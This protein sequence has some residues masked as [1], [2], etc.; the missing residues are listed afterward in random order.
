MTTVHAATQ[1]TIPQAFEQLVRN[2][3][4]KMIAT[5]ATVSLFLYV[6]EAA[7]AF[8]ILFGS[9]FL[10]ALVWKFFSLAGHS[11]RRK[12]RPV[13]NAKTAAN[14][15]NLIG[16]CIVSLILGGGLIFAAQAVGFGAS[17]LVSIGLVS[18]IAGLA[19]RD[20]ILNGVCAILIFAGGEFYEG[21]YLYLD[22]IH[23]GFVIV[24]GMQKT[25]LKRE[26]DGQKKWIKIPNQLVYQNAY[27]IS[28]GPAS[29][30][31]IKTVKPQKRQIG[32]TIEMGDEIFQVDAATA[33]HNR[34]L[35]Y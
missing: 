22:A 35:H 24:V 34:R 3:S 25:V 7:I 16:I 26:K 18:A 8:G 2:L 27:V 1:M 13:S 12:G 31:G 9:F 14:I 29:A 32:A 33:L 21:D 5:R 10:A 20:I 30:S 17:I 28:E 23:Q 6:E 15:W 4:P 19:S 11:C